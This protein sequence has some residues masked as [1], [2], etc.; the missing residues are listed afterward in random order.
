[1]LTDYLSFN[2][3]GA[4][5][6]KRISYA[7]GMME[8]TKLDPQVIANLFVQYQRDDF[9]VGIGIRDLFDKEYAYAQPFDSG[10]RE[11]PGK[12]REFFLKASWAFN[13]NPFA[14]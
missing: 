12:G 4:F 5:I 2:L 9:S 10:V 1:M 6:S 7:V 14:N 13:G 8:R 11:L 3:N